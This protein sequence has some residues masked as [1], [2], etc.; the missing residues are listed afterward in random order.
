MKKVV[1]FGEIMLRL[2]PPGFL[3]FS[4]TDSFD[5]VYGGGESNVAVSLANFGIPVDFVTRLPKNDLGTCAMMEIWKPVR[6]QE[7]AKWFTTVH[8]PRWRKSNRG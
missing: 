8:I 2:S 6:S 3:R 1:T 7:E 5:V 4:Q